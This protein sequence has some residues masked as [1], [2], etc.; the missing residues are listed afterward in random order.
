MAKTEK[1]TTNYFNAFIEVAD[2]CPVD[3]AQLPPQKGEA[4]TIAHL[5]HERISAQPYAFTSDEILFGIHCE[6]KGITG[7]EIDHEKE[8]WFSKG[9]PCLR[10]SPLAKRYGWGIHADA[11]GKVALV[12]LGSEEYD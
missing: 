3:K 2:D 8:V 5:Q 1:H 12:P 9:Q 11:K 6:R 4:T 10:S 7:K